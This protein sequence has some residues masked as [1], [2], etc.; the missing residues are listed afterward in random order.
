[1]DF[2]EGP[3]GWFLRKRRAGLGRDSLPQLV[4]RS[5][6]AFRTGVFRRLN[7]ANGF[8]RGL[9]AVL[10]GVRSSNGR[11]FPL[12]RRVGGLQTASF[13]AFCRGA[14]ARRSLPTVR[15][16]CFD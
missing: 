7:D 13:P 15:N 16:G 6:F 8:R 1:M 2:K 11:A 4:F 5:V 12:F 14:S 9:P 3:G 10:A